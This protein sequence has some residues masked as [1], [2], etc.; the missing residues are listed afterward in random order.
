[1]N[2]IAVF[3]LWR[4]LFLW[5]SMKNSPDRSGMAFGFCG[6]ECWDKACLVRTVLFRSLAIDR[7][8]AIGTDSRPFRDDE[9]PDSSLLLNMYYCE[10][11]I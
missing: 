8:K 4:R 10:I 1:M 7:L 3:T 5:L 11:G 6:L 9:A 2:E